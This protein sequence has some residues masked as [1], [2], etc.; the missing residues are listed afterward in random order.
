MD[1]ID[2]LIGRIKKRVAD[3]L[4]A[5]DAAEW[6]R[7][8]PAMAPPATEA[9][10]DAAEAALGFPVPLLLRRLYTEVGNGGWGPFYGLQGIPTD[11]AKPDAN[12]IIGFYLEC[13]SSE[14]A[15]ESPAVQWPRGLITLISRG[16]VDYEVCSFVRPPYPVFR[17]SGDTWDPERPV[18][19]SLEPVAESLE[20]RLETWEVS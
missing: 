10:V 18:E 3:P 1:G 12:D 16:C 8:I 19:E 13:I 11:G 15:L 6:V 14:R 2:R 4:R 9:D 20:G 17:L 7:P 5:V